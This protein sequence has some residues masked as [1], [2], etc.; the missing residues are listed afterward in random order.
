MS[1][2]EPIELQGAWSTSSSTPNSAVHLTFELS[3]ELAY[4][5]LD[6]FS[7]GP[8]V[9]VEMNI[10]EL[11]LLLGRLHNLRDVLINNIDCDDEQ[12]C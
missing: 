10:Y 2:L 9:S 7:A 3:G 8:S 11:N 5:T 1:D 6:E 4:V 12:C